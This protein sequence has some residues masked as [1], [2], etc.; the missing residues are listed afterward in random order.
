MTSEIRT[1]SLKSRAGLS[2]VTFTD[3]G[4]MFSGITTFVDNSTFSVG[5]GGT[6]HA[7]ATNVMALGTNNIDAIKI[8]SS[9]NVNITGIITASSI[10]GAISGD[11][12][13]SQK[14]VHT[15][16]TDTL[17]EFATDTISFDTGGSERFRIDSGG[18]FLLNMSTNVTGG[19]FQVNSGANFF[20]AS[21]DANGCVL[22]LEKTRSTSPG[23]YT[24]VQ[25]GDKLGELRFRGSNG[26]ASVIGANIQAVV[27]GTP[28]SGNDLPTDLV[29][30]LMPDGSGSTLERLRITSSGQVLIGTTTEGSSGAD[31]LTIATSGDTGMT[32]RSGTSSAGGIYFSDDTS[33]AGEY[34]GV[35]NYNHAG[36]YMRFYTNSTERARISS[37]GN[38]LIGTSTA[39][40][41]AGKGLMIADAAGARIKLCDSDQGVTASDGFEIIASNGGNAFIYNR[42]NSPI[43]I[44][45]NN[46]ERMRITHEGSVG[47]GTDGSTYELEVH[48][49]TGASALRMKDGPSNVICDLIANSTG[50]LLRTVYNHPLV[51]STA[52]VERMR[53]NHHGFVKMMGDMSSHMS[54]DGNNYHEMQADNPHIQILNMKHGSSNGYGIMMQFNHGKSTH[55]AFRVY[56]YASGS[57]NAF[58][59]TDGDLENINNSY[60]G[61]SDVK[62]KENIVDASSQWDDIKALR[63]RNFNY[64]SDESKTK[65]LGL[66]AQ[67]AEQVCPSLVKDQP[68]LGEENEDL[69]TTTK[70]MKYSIVYMKAIK[71]LQEAQE[72]IE[73]AEE[74]IEKLEQDNIALRVRVTNLEGN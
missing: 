10:S 52:Q 38:L 42:E 13:V 30:R 37:D 68:D 14:I 25:D 5:T 24:I 58:I 41:S 66:V 55:W 51:F 72:R 31:E 20:A 59:R 54:A 61:T 45:T 28:G 34:A 73:K 8:D 3:S 35:L 27:N 16:D 39:A 67:E 18:R 56:N 4:P 47:I 12:S 26:S 19:M 15:G 17:I 9:G 40:I 29:F 60:G 71:A 2:T 70:F 62:L 32:I 69:G 22:Q 23:N 74:R 57:T 48:D 50:G 43:I 1:N 21:N 6:I 33:G 46:T 44:G 65:M 49:P 7:P 64:K 53:I 11:L 63:V 36:N